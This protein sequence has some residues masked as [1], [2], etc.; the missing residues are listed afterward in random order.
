ML[1]S[2]WVSQATNAFIALQGTNLHLI[3]LFRI[4]PANLSLVAYSS[5]WWWGQYA[6]LKVGLLQWDYTAL[7][8]RRVSSLDEIIKLLYL[9]TLYQTVEWVVKVV[10]SGKLRGIKNEEAYSPFVLMS[11]HLTSG[12]DNNARLTKIMNTWDASRSWHYVQVR[13]YFVI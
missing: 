2:F 1:A 9:V 11:R 13:F 4:H 12:N 3:R 8:P 6:P 10:M 5:P 7:Y